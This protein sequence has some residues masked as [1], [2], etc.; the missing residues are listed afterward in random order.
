M[1]GRFLGRGRALWEALS[2]LGGRASGKSPL[3]A[4]SEN[5]PRRA[6]NHIRCGVRRLERFDLHP[7]ASQLLILALDLRVAKG[8]CAVA[9]RG[10]GIRRDN[11]TG[12]RIDLVRH[13][14]RVRG[15]VGFALR[16]GDRLSQ[17]LRIV[18]DSANSRSAVGPDTFVQ[19]RE[20]F[21]DR[22]DHVTIGITL[23]AVGDRAGDITS[24]RQSAHDRQHG[25]PIARLGVEDAIES[26]VG[27][28]CGGFRVEGRV[29]PL[30]GREVDIT[31]PHRLVLLARINWLALFID[32]IP[33]CDGLPL[34][35]GNG[36]GGIGHLVYS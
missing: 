22:P 4:G 23:R 1:G 20:A 24:Q 7:T 35:L 15:R 27:V 21:S 13:L 30:R 26:G 10:L 28:G 19:F 6:C 8:K 31:E 16:V 34:R 29:E 33:D 25:R 2:V 12:F 18:T 36:C 9:D 17:L 5:R 14:G 11:R 32:P 3:V